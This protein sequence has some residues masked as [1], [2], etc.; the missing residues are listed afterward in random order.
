MTV[1]QR[2]AT[3]QRTALLGALR[4][5]LGSVALLPFLPWLLHG[6]PGLSGLADACERWFS[7]QCQRDPS[8]A[9]YAFGHALPVC[10]RCSG[11]YFGFG[12]GACVAR[13]HLGA[14]LLRRWVAVACLFMLLDV[15]S[16]ALGMR[17]PW[18]PLRVMSGM[19]LAYPVGVASLSALRAR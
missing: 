7:F 18:A 12:L 3:I 11:I 9:L 8:R 4:A 15:L 10:A 5:L 1:S 6:V 2:S 14:P 19:L 17:A 13:P 16:E